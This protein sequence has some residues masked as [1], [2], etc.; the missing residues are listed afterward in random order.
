MLLGMTFNELPCNWDTLFLH[1]ISK[2]SSRLRI[3]RVCKHCGCSLQ[4]LIL[5]FDSLVMSLF[6][7]AIEVWACAYDGI[8]FL[9]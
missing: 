6:N 4:E 8:T 5:L 1:M 7:Y 3:S 9:R 2:A